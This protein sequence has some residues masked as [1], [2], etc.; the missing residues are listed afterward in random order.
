MEN[1]E[2]ADV[3]AR[4]AGKGVHEVISDEGLE[5]IKAGLI[6]LRPRQLLDS[7]GKTAEPIEENK[8]SDITYH[9]VNHLRQTCDNV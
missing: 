1:N 5:M 4:R 3:A 2:R 9:D 7:D 8:N 6:T